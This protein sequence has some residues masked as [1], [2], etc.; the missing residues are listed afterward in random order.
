MRDTMAIAGR[1]AADPDAS[2]LL[3]GETGVGKGW[4][5]RRIHLESPRRERAYVELNCASMTK[6]LVESELFGHV[7][8]AFT[9]AESSKPGLVEEADGGTLFLDEIAELPLDVQARLLTFLDTEQYRPLGSVATRTVDVRIIAAT[10]ADLEEAVRSRTFR[11]DLYHRLAVLPIAIPPL[12]ERLEDLPALAASMLRELCECRSA[13]VEV[14]PAA[15]ASLA[16]YDWPGN[17]RE[18][19][20]V[21]ERAL[22]LSH[23]VIDSFERFLP[24]TETQARRSLRLDDVMRAHVLEVLRSVDGNRTIA[25]RRLGIGRSTLKRKL[26]EYRESAETAQV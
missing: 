4:L 18:L 6:E 1:A 17:V 11:A 22:V 16:R 3:L 19:R 25:A 2:I 15:L 14:T 26:R 21:L 24:R 9:G 20:N 13:P 5:A 23:G 10:N 8:G 7:R 12:R